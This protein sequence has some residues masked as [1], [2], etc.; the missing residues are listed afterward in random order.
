S[1]D[2]APTTCG[3]H[4]VQDVLLRHDPVCKKAFNGK[5]KP[6][7]ILKQRLQGTEI[8]TVKKQ[9]PQKLYQALKEGHPLPPPPP[10]RM[11]P[12]YIQCPH[13]SQRFSGAAAQRHMEFSEGQGVDHAAKTTGQASDKQPLTQRKTPTLTPAV[14]SLLE[15]VQKGANT[16][17]PSLET[18]LEILKKA[19]KS[20]G[21]S[22]GKNS[23]GKFGPQVDNRR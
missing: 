9:A 2:L 7:S 12:E 1:Q 11:N 18:S 22:T 23:S 4:S 15:K 17:K 19:G 5:C 3:K 21:V 10:P 16:D 13:C 6:F 8:I 20:W 14:L